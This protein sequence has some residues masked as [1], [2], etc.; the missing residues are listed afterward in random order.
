[1]RTA[2]TA[3]F[4]GY[5][6]S[7]AP[8]AGI[9]SV[10]VTDGSVTD[11]R[12][13]V[14]LDRRN[15]GLSPQRQIFCYKLVPHISISDGDDVLWIDGSM[16]PTGKDVNE[17]FDLVPPGGVGIHRHPQRDCFW[18]EALF[19]KQDQRYAE[20]DRGLRSIEQGEYY[21]THGCP[22]HG[23]LWATGI[24]VWRGAQKTI[25]ER[26][27]AETTNW[28]ASDQIALPYVLYR[29][30]TTITSLPGSVYQSPWFNYVEHGA[31]GRTTR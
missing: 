24:I 23:G 15:H 10:L 30:G 22:L 5:E 17:L 28:S 31:I 26:W 7:K 29:L 21:K 6:R 16:E 9:R 20:R 13:N 25:G 3:I 27:F 19:S 12:W 18:D 2:V 11:D 1:M 8:P 14:T 4:N